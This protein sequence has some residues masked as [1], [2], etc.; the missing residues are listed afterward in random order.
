M[1]L[2]KKLTVKSVLGRKPSAALLGDKSDVSLMTVYGKASTVEHGEHDFGDGN[3]SEYDKFKGD[4]EAVRVS[5]GVVIRS[6]VMILPE[7]AG[8]LLATVVNGLEEG[9]GAV[10]FAFM[11]NIRKDEGSTI[12]YQYEAEPLTKTEE[13][14]PLSN[15][16]AQLT[17][18][19]VPGLAAP[20]SHNVA[21]I[22]TV[23]DAAPTPAPEK[24]Q[25][26]RAAKK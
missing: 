26:A 20:D 5:D 24:K 23:K 10:E 22:G 4:F 2:V 14:D 7:V 12:G 3:T 6:A 16:R 11:I 8:D 1:K 13:K 18:R 9:Q 19:N 15:I 21:D 25:P 17:A